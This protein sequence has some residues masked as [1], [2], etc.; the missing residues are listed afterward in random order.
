MLWASI[1]IHGLVLFM[2]VAPEA[3]EDGEEVVA[4]ELEDFDQA[5]ALSAL[6]APPTLA[7]KASPPPTPVPRPQFTPV[8]RA[9]PNP[10]PNVAPT[11]DP[12]P[13]PEAEEP[14]AE[15]DPP[16]TPE[17]MTDEEN[18][19]DATDSTGSTDAT[20]ALADPLP[21]D[22]ADSRN[23]LLGSLGTMEGVIGLSPLV[24]Y[25][26]PPDAYFT[27]ADVPDTKD[28]A[29]WVEG[30]V[31]IDWY[32]SEFPDN[33]RPEVII[34]QWQA[35]FAAGGAVMQEVPEGYGRTRLFEVIQ[36][37]VPLL[38]L[39]IVPGTGNAST[40]VVQW[41]RNPNLPPE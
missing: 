34:A 11:P 8:P 17:A 6:Q 35:Q 21:S 31:G 4:E 26:R 13:S 20:D 16:E 18:A 24:S 9:T 14:A 41:D 12:T 10:V 36:N 32:N 33:V 25:F 7:P 28:P 27:A 29:Y 30:I 15:T 22:V 2:P 38:Y 5:I 40:V 23:A 39:N 1:L 19:T 37:E 3:A